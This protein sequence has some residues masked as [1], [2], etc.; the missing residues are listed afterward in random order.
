MGVTLAA[1]DV[2]EE[3]NNAAADRHAMNFVIFL[4]ILIPL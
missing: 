1:C 3:I 2:G 4:I